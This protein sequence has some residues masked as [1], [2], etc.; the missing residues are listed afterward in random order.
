MCS[1]I[2]I[3]H[4]LFVEF[5]THWHVVKTLAYCS[6]N[7]GSVSW[8]T[9]FKTLPTHQPGFHRTTRDNQEPLRNHAVAPRW[10]AAKT[11]CFY[12]SY[13]WGKTAVINRRIEKIF[14]T[15]KISSSNKLDWIF[16]RKCI[17]MTEK[18]R[19]WITGGRFLGMT[20]CAFNSVITRVIKYFSRFYR[21]LIHCSIF[22]ILILDQV[23]YLQSIFPSGRNIRLCCIFAFKYSGITCRFV[24]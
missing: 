13:L 23:Q 3:I 9:E 2:S 20:S 24:L 5:Y 16:W 15:I 11:N 4:L 8:W 14:L 12:F 10:G 18:L 6:N 22:H 17:G 19:S 1:A 21:W 7:N